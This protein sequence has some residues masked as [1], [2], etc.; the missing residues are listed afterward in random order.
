MR[1][2]AA[3]MPY[4]RSGRS[5][6]QSTHSGIPGCALGTGCW[7]RGG[8]VLR[9]GWGRRWRPW[10]AASLHCWCPAAG[11]TCRR[12]PRRLHLQVILYIFALNAQFCSAR[13]CGGHCSAVAP[14]SAA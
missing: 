8:R 12:P 3:G 13:E 7:R 10:A 4:A 1:A 5:I 9:R 2:E 14:G 11:L 6:T